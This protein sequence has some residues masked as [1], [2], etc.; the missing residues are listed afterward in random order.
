MPPFLASLELARNKIKD[1]QQSGLEGESWINKHQR[2]RSESDA[3]LIGTNKG[4]AV[5]DPLS[6]PTRHSREKAPV[7][8]SRSSEALQARHR[9]LCLQLLE[10]QQRAI[11][12]DKAERLRSIQWAGEA[13]Y[14]QQMDT[15]ERS[16]RESA[17]RQ[18]RQRVEVERRDVE[19]KTEE[20]QREQTEVKRL[21]EE[22]STYR[23]KVEQAKR[24]RLSRMQFDDR[25]RHHKQH[26]EQIKLRVK[27]ERRAD[28]RVELQTSAAPVLALGLM[29]VQSDEGLRKR[30]RYELHRD[31]LLLFAET[32]SARRPSLIQSHLDEE[33]PL[34]R[35]AVEPGSI[36]LIRDDSEASQTAHSFFL[37]YHDDEKATQEV[38]RAFTD[39][40]AEKE[41]LLIGLSMLSCYKLTDNTFE[42]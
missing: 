4:W 7:M 10:V 11:D 22:A 35:V 20:I 30:R 28:L 19:R 42:S 23:G 12:M 14:R 17:E 3:H 32:G 39:T 29:T 18:A 25:E 37:K 33:E 31:E 26:Q 38:L 5:T 21:M 8:Q 13:I 6:T 34:A 15:F 2:E 41:R 24:E 16:Q 27:A 9:S 36:I 40:E 1:M